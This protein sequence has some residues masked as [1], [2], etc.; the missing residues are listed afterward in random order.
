[1][2][3]FW[4]RV[5]VWWDICCVVAFFNGFLPCVF[6]TYEYYG[7]AKTK[8]LLN[9]TKYKVSSTTIRNVFKKDSVL[10]FKYSNNLKG[11]HSVKPV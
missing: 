6:S 7:K 1:M 3:L 5:V 8:L 4:E 10:T 2:G 11:K 9:S